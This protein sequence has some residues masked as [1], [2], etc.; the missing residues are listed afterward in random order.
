[1]LKFFYCEENNPII[2]NLAFYTKGFKFN[3]IFSSFF[4]FF[5]QAFGIG[6]WFTIQICHGIHDPHHP[7]YLF[8]Q[9]EIHQT[10]N[11]ISY[12]RLWL[13]FVSSCRSDNLFVVDKTKVEGRR[14]CNCRTSWF[15]ETLA[16]DSITLTKRHFKANELIITQ[17]LLFL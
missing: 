2:I 6:F 10:N 16:S 14:C 5:L 11:N 4:F 12:L 7:F 17:R 3:P 1:M 13:V 15:L 8:E 9:N